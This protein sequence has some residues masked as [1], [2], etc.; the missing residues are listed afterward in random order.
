MAYNF[1]DD[2]DEMTSSRKE[3]NKKNSKT[4][5]LDNFGRNLT[6]LA[7]EGKLDPVYGRQQEVKRVAQIL[8]RRT[9]NNPIIIGSSGVGKTSIAMLLAQMIADKSAPRSLHNKQIIEVD[10]GSIVS[11]TKFRGQFEERIK[12]IIQEVTS[13]PSII[14]FIDEIHTIIG[15]G[16]ASGSLDAANMIKPSLTRG[17]FQIIGSTTLDEY[18]M[19]I[20]KDPALDRRFQKVVLEPTSIEDTIK[21]LNSIKDR[22]EDHHKVSYTEEAINACVKLTDRYI[23]DRYLP[24]KAIDVLDEVGSKIHLEL[25]APSDIKNLEDKLNDIKKV[26]SVAVSKQQYEEAAKLR[27]EEK[28][29]NSHLTIE[30]KKWETDLNTNRIL[31]TEDM[32]ADVVS[33]MSGIPVNKV[34]TA[35][36]K[37]L[38]NLQGKIE[39]KVIGQQE[40]VIATTKAIKRS[41]IGMK[42]NNKPISFMFI[43]NSG[44]GKT[45][46]AKAL[47][48]ELFDGRDSM[49]RFDM[50]EYTEKINVSKLIGAAPGYVGFEQGGKLTEAVR[51]KPYSVVLFDEIEKAHPDIYNIFLQVLDE[52]HLTDSHGIKVDFK[53]TLIIMTSN[54]GTRTVKQF[55]T[56]IGFDSSSS[57]KNNEKLATITKELNKQFSPEFLNRLDEIIFFKDLDSDNVSDILKIEILKVQKRVLGLGYELVLTQSALDF[58]AEKGYD[59][60]N[61]ARPIK[62]AIQNHVEDLLTEEL[63]KDEDISVGSIFTVDY[64]KKTDSLKVKRKEGKISK[65]KIN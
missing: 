11:G 48:E 65:K 54:V 53:N 47:A 34:N 62:R 46:L 18:R 19:H 41:R 4:P 52:G 60:Q 15:A 38:S 28:T 56:G 42:D 23:N 17:D 5:V 6:K 63:V 43:G 64:D 21:I 25:K 8:T 58:L 3:Q 45:L 40:A 16:G 49:I 55:G 59:I 22:Y 31:V 26:K 20:E 36:K 9:K 32:V 14:L 39:A 33:A 2:D 51:R 29:I 10:M 7:E 35:D 13:N 24:D 12:A 1:D 30:N 61:G 27:D 50:S 57:T 44:V 37:S